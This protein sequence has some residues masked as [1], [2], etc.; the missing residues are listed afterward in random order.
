VAM[1]KIDHGTEFNDKFPFI[2]ANWSALLWNNKRVFRDNLIDA[3][4]E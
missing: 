4:C 3:A 1:I 2:G